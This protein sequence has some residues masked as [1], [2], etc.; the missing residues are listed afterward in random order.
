DVEVLAF[1]ARNDV[2]QYARAIPRVR[3]LARTGRFDLLHAHYGLSGA[4][5]L[6]QRSV[7]VVTTFHGSDT[8]YVAWQRIVSAVV[9]RRAV[10][11]FVHRAGARHL[12]C[13]NGYVIPAGVDTELFVPVDC[14]AARRKLGWSENGPYI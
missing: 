5:A 1:D 11:I 3:Q 12:W 9:A 6:T 8:G 7:P 2:T 10:P 4:V 13:H 14:S